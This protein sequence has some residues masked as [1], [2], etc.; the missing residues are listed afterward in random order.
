MTDERDGLAAERSWWKEAV[1]YQIYPWSFKDSDGDGVGDLQGIIEKLDYLDDLGVDVVWLNPVYRSPQVDNGYDIADYQAIHEEFGTM[2]DWDALLEGLHARGMK[3]IMD[4]VVNH[5]SSEHEWFITSRE[6]PDGEYG[7]YYIWVDGEPDEQPNNWES[8]FGGPAWTYDETRG[9]WYLHLFHADQ[10][11]LNWENPD[12]REDVYR[13]MNWWLDRGIDGFRLDVI[14]L[15]SKPEHLPDGDPDSDLWTGG[16]HYINGPN[17]FQHLGEMYDRTYSNYDTM[18][19]GEMATVTVE[20]ARDYTGI[21]GPLDMVFNF[22]HLRLDFGEEG[23]WDVG[24][25]S[26]VELK[27]V[28]GEW[29]TGLLSDGWPSVF[30]ENHDQP[31]SVSCF[32]DPDRYHRES[33]T[34]LATVLLTLR[35]TPYIYQGE[36]LGMTN[37][38]FESLDDVR[39]V[40]TIQN[41]REE[42]AR[43]GIDDYDDF[44]H[45]VEYRSRD[46]ARTPMQWDATENAG[47]TTGEP[48]IDVTP[49]HVD[50]NVET[51]RETPGSVWHYYRDLIAIRHESDVLV[52][53]DYHDFLPT[54]EQVWAYTRTLGKNRVFVVCNFS[55][56]PV[57]R[58]LPIVSEGNLVIAN[59]PNA[60]DSLGDLELRPYEAR[61]YELE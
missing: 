47:F 11:D 5:T 7:D 44:R 25:W 29:Q 36:E 10:P 43:R 48:W 9:A 16:G 49:N 23:R 39:D 26:L 59:Y 31:R 19:V 42:M 3:L 18:T 8:F 13:M 37:T 56:D 21:N 41:V 6:N 54:D 12:L 4:L 50:I 40:D 51:E 33:A 58:P 35:G 24:E 46:N 38:T 32:G 30:F 27:E 1:V 22:D 34:L 52:Y 60:P 55:G 53:G 57:E 14:N 15:I 20:Q 61:V 2:A 17:V 45:I 28:L